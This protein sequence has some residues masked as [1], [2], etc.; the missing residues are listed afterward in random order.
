MDR[1]VLPI[2][3]CNFKSYIALTFPYY[4]Y[5]AHIFSLSY[6]VLISLIFL[7]PFV[8]CCA[9]FEVHAPIINNDFLSLVPNPTEAEAFRPLERGHSSSIYA[10]NSSKRFDNLFIPSKFHQYNWVLS[11][12]DFCLANV[13]LESAL[14]FDVAYYQSSFFD[15]AK[16][17]ATSPHL[18]LS[19]EMETPRLL[20]DTHIVHQQNQHQPL[21]RIPSDYKQPSSSIFRGG[22]IP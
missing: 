12:G 9:H 13:H 5:H 2:F 15:V 22:I 14:I 3:C 21:T 1:L 8:G 20:I 18:Y 10:H 16:C 7:L 17:F 6:I 19:S 11:I 4:W